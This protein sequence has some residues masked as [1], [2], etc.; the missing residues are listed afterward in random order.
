MGR[1]LPALFASV[2]LATIVV[3]DWLA[4]S[5]VSAG[6]AFRAWGVASSC[7]ILIGVVTGLLV[8]WQ[9]APFVAGSVIAVLSGHP[10]LML[11]FAGL[12]LI[13]VARSILRRRRWHEGV[14]WDRVNRALLTV[15]A[16]A[17]GIGLLQT[18]MVGAWA[19][20]LPLTSRK[21]TAPSDAP[22]MYV[23]LLDGYA[24]ADTLARFGMDNQPFLSALQ[25]R[26]FDVAHE[27]HSNYTA[28]WPT[29]ASMFDLRP[30]SAM[31]G[32]PS[33]SGPNGDQ[34]RALGRIARHGRALELLR[35]HGY[36]IVATPSAFAEL[37]LSTADRLPASG[38]ASGFEYALLRRTP[39]ARLQPVVDWAMSDHRDRIDD[40]LRAGVEVASERD[41]PPVFMW[42]HL[43]APHSPL[44]FG[45][46]PQPCFPSCT[47]YEP[48]AEE[49]GLTPK[50]FEA[51]FAAQTADLNDR[52]LAAVDEI[53]ANSARPPAIVLMS[54]HGVRHVNGPEEYF[55]SFFA[56]RTPGHNAVFPQ[57]NA[58]SGTLALLLNAYLDANVPVP[59]PEV[60]MVSE[61]GAVLNMRPWPVP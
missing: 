59:D 60:R 2:L 53:T 18:V 4:Q 35:S 17:L 19:P 5:P 42:I 57:D 6:D 30:I 21:G 48:K 26:G 45:N 61:R 8:G 9:A 11:V 43:M 27:S 7:A 50:R 34:E 10:V 3:L 23:I 52:I 33:G 44:V 16:V 22:D 28:T 31:Q 38:H 24:R 15:A 14:P 49:W 29:L 12:G 41:R 56:A 55:A 39:L 20:D 58:A 36:E 47:F 46:P 54:D 13:Q 1:S 40:Q 25:S 32:L 51:A 37:T